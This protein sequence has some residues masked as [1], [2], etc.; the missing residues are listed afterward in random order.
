MGGYG[1][2]AEYNYGLTEGAHKNPAASQLLHI[3]PNLPQTSREAGQTHW[4]WPTIYF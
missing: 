2:K 3:I 4:P 1:R